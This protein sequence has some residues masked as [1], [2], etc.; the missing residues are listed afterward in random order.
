MTHFV[1]RYSSVKGRDKKQSVERRPMPR[2]ELVLILKDIYDSNDQTD[3]H[4]DQPGKPNSGRR[5]WRWLLKVED[6]RCGHFSK[7]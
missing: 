1:D 3:N 4:S 5:L 6:R 7:G 2:R